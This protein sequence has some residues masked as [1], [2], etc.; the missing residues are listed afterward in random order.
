M[1]TDCQMKCIGTWATYIIQIIVGVY[2]ALVVCCTI[3]CILVTGI[4]V[5]CVVCA[6]IDG[7]VQGDYAVA[8]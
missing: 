2:A 5:I 8:A 1:Q 7:K 4:L 6:V 3:P